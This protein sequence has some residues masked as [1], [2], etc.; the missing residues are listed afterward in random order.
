M[1][2]SVTTLDRHLIAAAGVGCVITVMVVMLL[3]LRKMW[4]RLVMR[5]LRLP[6][7]L[8]VP[9]VRRRALSGRDGP[10]LTLSRR[11]QVIRRLKDSSHKSQP[12]S[13]NHQHAVRLTLAVDDPFDLTAPSPGAN[14][15]ST[16]SSRL[17][18]SS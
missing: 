8:L 17:L 7:V 16:V 1:T 2:R 3:M 10:I 15:P 9:E 18:A 6:V 11:G 4:V 12:S 5:L 14:G 13:G